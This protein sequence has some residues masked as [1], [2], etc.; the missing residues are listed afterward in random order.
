M[1]LDSDSR[2]TER[3][4]PDDLVGRNVLERVTGKIPSSCKLQN[5]HEALSKDS[6]LSNANMNPDGFQQLAVVSGHSCL[7]TD[8]R[9][10]EVGSLLNAPA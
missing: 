7:P 5:E 9:N 3:S 4:S 1:L 8:R 2:M 10:G 6:K